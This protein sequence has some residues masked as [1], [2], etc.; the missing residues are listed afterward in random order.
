MIKKINR[1][2]DNLENIMACLTL[3]A[4]VA[5]IFIGVIARYIFKHPLTFID[6]LS[7]IVIVWGVI[8]GY[9]IA[10]RNDDHIKM[11]ALYCMI[12]S[13][14][15]KSAMVLFSY[16]CGFLYSN[17]II[18]YGWRAVMMQY[19]LH[20]V[21]MMLEFPVWITYLVI[22]FIGAVMDI[23]YLMLAVRVFRPL[24]TGKEE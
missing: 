3:V 19:K 13:V 9:S 15:V 18:W 14:Y 11:D 1:W 8:I 20:R 21:T 4:G 12:K 24:K 2:Y 5:M 7:T 16:A 22:P 6:E 17:F 10:L 23:R